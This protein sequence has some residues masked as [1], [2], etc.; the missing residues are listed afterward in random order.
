MMPGEVIPSRWWSLLV[1]IDA[2][3]AWS[4]QK[5]RCPCCGGR[6]DSGH[7]T[8]KVRG[9]VDGQGPEAG[10]RWSWCCS[11]EGCRKRVT[12][13][14]VRFWGRLVY[15]GAV[16]V[17]LAGEA[18]KSASGNR[19]W[20][21]IGCARQT[22]ARWRSRFAGLWETATGRMIAGWLTLS[23]QQRGDVC[24]VLSQWPGSWPFRAARWQLLIHPLTGGTSWEKP[25]YPH[26]PLDPQKMDFAQPLAVLEGVPRSW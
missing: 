17:A 19:L 13:P 2:G 26:R 6:L 25:R 23:G 8:R 16:V 9:L 5:A 10:L 14:S 1:L 15:A 11:R 7:Y 20:R 18:P 24:V 12:P 3:I 21:L 4:V 22:W